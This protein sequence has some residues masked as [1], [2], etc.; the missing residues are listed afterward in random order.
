LANR[1]NQIGR[2]GFGRIDSIVLPNGNQV[3]RKTFDPSPEVL[4]HI[5]IN[6]FKNRFLREIKVLETLPRS[7]FL[8]ILGE[9]VEVDEPWFM[10]P[11]AEA[12]LSK[13]VGNWKRVLVDVLDGLELLHRAGYV[14]RDLNPD[15][16]VFHEGKWKLIDF[17]IVLAM[18]ESVPQLRF[19]GP[20][21]GTK[22]YSSLEQVTSFNGVT[23]AADI[24]SFGCLLHDYIS[25]NPR[26]PFQQHSADGTLGRIVQRCTNGN[27]YQRYDSIK[28]LRK[29]L[30]REL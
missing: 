28:S 1:I 27:P 4:P 7:H 12:S 24:Y 17:G 20:A 11:I 22:G 29:E 25:S 16:V 15:N 21:W 26:E 18:G 13:G 3:A 6:K 9:E 2:G 10:M 23:I 8:P 19:P 5:N 30:Y 14:H